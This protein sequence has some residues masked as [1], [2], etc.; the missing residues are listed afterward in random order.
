MAMN[1]LIVDDSRV[2]RAMVRRVLRM[3]GIPLDSVGE[4][5]NGESALAA[6]AAGPCDLMLL[7]VN[8]PGMT[9]L[10]L[11]ERLRASDAT[12]QLPVVVVSTEG[13]EPR[14]K[15]MKDMGASFVRK[16]FAPEELVD[17]VIGAIGGGN[18]GFG[19]EPEAAGGEDF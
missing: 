16:P 10:E 5:E 6:L 14:V 17:A 13:N 12:K 2:M 7:D 15:A 8:M 3:S 9:G 18:V 4:A 1:V 19:E 11:L